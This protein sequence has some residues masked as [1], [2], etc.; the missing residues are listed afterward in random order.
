MS[1]AA[2]ELSTAEELLAWTSGA[3]AAVGGALGA[4]LEN[5]A[6][7]NGWEKN[8]K[9]YLLTPVV[10]LA[11]VSAFFSSSASNAAHLSGQADQALA[12]T[13]A[14][15]PDGGATTEDTGGRA[16]REAFNACANATGAWKFKETDENA[17]AAAKLSVGGADGGP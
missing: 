5:D 2:D 15:E 9:Y 11:A 16:Y 6:T 7:G 1:K 17:A 8:R 12:L 3:A 4:T 13:A 14:F 10:P